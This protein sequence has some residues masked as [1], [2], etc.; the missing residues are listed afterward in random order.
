MPERVSRTAGVSVYARAD[1][2]HLYI[3][4]IDPLRPNRYRVSEVTPFRKDDPEGMRKA[5]A[6]AME[7]A[8]DA[9]ISGSAAQKERWESWVISFLDFQYRNPSQAL[10]LKRYKGAWKWLSLF[11]I[12]EQGVRVPRALTYQH[13]RD[14]H[15]WRTNFKK[16]SGKQVSSTTATH[17]TK[18][19]IVIMNEAVHRGYAPTNVCLRLKLPRQETRHARELLPDELAK[20]E[21]AL[22]AWVALD[23]KERAFMPI[24]YQ[25]GRYQGCRLRETRLDLKRCVNLRTATIT[26]HTKGK[27]DGPGE[28]VMMHPKLKPLFEQLI[29]EGKQWTLDYGVRPSLL[30]RWFFDSIGLRDAWF[31]CLRS[32]AITE[33]A[34]AG[35]PISIAM[36]YVLHASEEMHRA[37][38]RLNTADLA[39]AAASIGS[40]AVP[41]QNATQDDGT[42][43]QAAIIAEL[44]RGG[45][46]LTDA[47]RQVA[48]ASSAVKVPAPVLPGM[49]APP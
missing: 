22:P 30:W 34:R 20:I 12:R 35:V 24:A 49:P 37:Y 47:M 32:T 33:M 42:R 13:M 9:R 6:L 29:A 43:L 36:R 15:Q 5:N 10:T 14:F 16:A 17:D 41:Y 19:M 1:R 27:K 31:H 18:A 38:Q 7:K 21:R 28:A 45:M 26:F 44:V 8:K 39:S 2:Q 46:G 25:I 23:P 48:H 40:A 4:Y 11:L 3:S